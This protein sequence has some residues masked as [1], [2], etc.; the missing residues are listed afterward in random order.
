MR[1]KFNLN[2]AKIKQI[3][4]N[5]TTHIGRPALTRLGDAHAHA[6]QHFDARQL[7]PG[8][9]WARNFTWNSTSSPQKNH[10]LVL[11]TVILLVAILFGILPDDLNQILETDTSDEDIAIL[12]DE[13]P[14][15]VYID[16]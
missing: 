5:S 3:L 1:A 4:D 9:A 8:L 11:T 7:T 10:L 2:H 15:H 12:T 14:M 13:L 16:L 6:L